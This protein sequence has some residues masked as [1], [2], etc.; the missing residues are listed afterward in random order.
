MSLSQ[1][2]SSGDELPMIHRLEKLMKLGEQRIKQQEQLLTMAQEECRSQSLA[3]NNVIGQQA[4]VQEKRKALADKIFSGEDC[5]GDEYLT[6]KALMRL[7]DSLQFLQETLGSLE[8]QEIEMKERLKLASNK[9]DGCRYEIRR[10]VS[11]KEQLQSCVIALKGKVRARQ[12]RRAD[13]NL[14]ERYCR[15]RVV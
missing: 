6:V 13:A 8:Q 9:R 7:D 11:R 3:I 10:Q 2:L 5:Q 15:R 14:E 12:E 1:S 4:S